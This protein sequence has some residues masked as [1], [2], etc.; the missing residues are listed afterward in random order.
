MKTE[1]IIVLSMALLAGGMFFLNDPV[2]QQHAR[3]AEKTPES[4]DVRYRRAYLQLAKAE[5]EVLKDANKR[6]KGTYTEGTVERFQQHVGIAREQLQQT[7]LAD[8]GKLHKVHVLEAEAVLKIAEGRLERALTANRRLSGAVRD[9][10]IKRLRLVVEVARLGLA[11]AR[12][13]ASTQSENAH[14]QWQLDGLREDVL[15]LQLRVVELSVRG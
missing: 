14:L 11:R 5:L 13:P 2:A 1:R 6:V 12:D 4:V 8:Q 9:V 7:L 3:S 10:E 15:R